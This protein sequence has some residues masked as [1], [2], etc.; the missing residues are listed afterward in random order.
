MGVVTP[1]IEVENQNQGNTAYD[2]STI[3]P[4]PSLSFRPL[5]IH[6]CSVIELEVNCCNGVVLDA[7]GFRLGIINNKEIITFTVSDNPLKLITFS[8]DSN[9]WYKNIKKKLN[10]G[11]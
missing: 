8:N 9:I 2:N 3:I 11:N 4:P 7:D 5:L 1:L 10:W 6:H